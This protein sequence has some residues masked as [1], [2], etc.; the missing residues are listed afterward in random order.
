MNSRTCKYKLILILLLCGILTAGTFPV[1]VW[2]ATKGSAADQDAKI[3]Q[4]SNVGL[5]AKSLSV[6]ASSALVTDSKRGQVLYQKNPKTKIHI[7]TASKI[8]TALLCIEKSKLDAKVTISKESVESIEGEGSLLNLGVGEKYTVEELLYALLLTSANDVANALAE[9]VGGDMDNFTKMMNAKAKDLK[10]TDTVFMNPSGLYDDS[11]YTTAYDISL[12][13]QEALKNPVFNNLFA[14]K[15]RPW[16]NK[17]GVQVLTNQNK[18]FWSY[19][20]VDGGKTGYNNKNQISAITT[21]TRNNQRLICIVLESPEKEVFTD[22]TLLL[23]YCFNNFK[24]GI[25]VS[26]G[27]VIRTTEIEGKAINLISR[28]PVY[29]TFPKGED[30]IKS[31]DISLDQNLKLPLTIDHMVGNARYT[32]MDGT[33]ID[34]SL[35]PE[36]DAAPPENT[37]SR[38]VKTLDA[39]RDILVL[40]IILCSIEILLILYNL[41]RFLFWIARKI[42]ARL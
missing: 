41:G 5:M 16:Y 6:K 23:D 19:D 13:L 10:L 25:L 38:I 7:S 22:S 30:F 26:K 2:A 34:V 31:L 1:Q 32:L 14:C 20:G 15:A 8:M 35:Y 24:A 18:L 12:L 29:Y 33:V 17:N 11:Q 4:P 36:R 40:L 28:E 42:K 3:Q 9:F 37:L 27:Q 39:N 21:V